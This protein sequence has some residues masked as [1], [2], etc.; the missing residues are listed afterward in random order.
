ME[1]GNVTEN[2]KKTYALYS[3]YCN[4]RTGHAEVIKKKKDSESIAHTT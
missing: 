1:T 2:E 3:C 4:K